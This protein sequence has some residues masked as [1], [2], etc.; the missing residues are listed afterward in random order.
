MFICVRYFHGLGRGTLRF[1]WTFS[2]V[3]L[4]LVHLHITIYTYKCIKFL[5]FLLSLTVFF[6]GLPSVSLAIFFPIHRH[7]HHLTHTGHFCSLLFWNV[8]HYSHTLYTSLL[9]P[10]PFF[11]RSYFNRNRS[12]FGTFRSHGLIYTDFYCRKI[13]CS[14]TKIWVLYQQH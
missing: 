7:P 1:R 9:S 2:V 11:S 8:Q 12:A 13:I 5:L 10:F 4:Q 14:G 3:L 6:N